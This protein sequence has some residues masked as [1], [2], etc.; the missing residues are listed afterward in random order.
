MYRLPQLE[1]DQDAG[2]TH[3]VDSVQFIGQSYGRHIPH[4]QTAEKISGGQ[5]RLMTET[6]IA[7]AAEQVQPMVE[8]INSMVYNY[9]GLLQQ[10]RVPAEVAQT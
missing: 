1:R 8:G 9:R 2:N 6:M 5:L 3:T 4:R 7:D 10:D